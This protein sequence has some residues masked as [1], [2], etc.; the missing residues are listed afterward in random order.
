MTR[1]DRLLMLVIVIIALAG[2]SVGGIQ[3][4]VRGI[5]GCRQQDTA[6]AVV[7]VKGKVVRHID[8]NNS[9]NLPAAI[10]GSN[11]GR[12][13]DAKTIRV[14]GPQGI[15]VLEIEE[16]KIRMLAS[17]C[18]DHICV[19]QG[20]ISKPGEAIVCVPNEVS[21]AVEGDGGVDAIIR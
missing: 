1:T 13:N 12:N 10:G 14:E 2:M 6:H 11:S 3:E 19:H 7:K 15:S 9:N 21:V 16:G 4:A 20:W 17:P 18:P 5:Q 8:L